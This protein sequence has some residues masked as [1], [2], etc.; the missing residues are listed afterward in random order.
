MKCNGAALG[1]IDSEIQCIFLLLNSTS[2]SKRLHVYP[3]KYYNGTS[4]WC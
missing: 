2:V 1:H 3:L 4:L